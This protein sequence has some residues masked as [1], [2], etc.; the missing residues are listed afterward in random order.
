LEDLLFSK[1]AAVILLL[2]Q[3]KQAFGVGADDMDPDLFTGH[4]HHC[5][6]GEG[7]RRVGNGGDK[8]ICG[9]EGHGCGYL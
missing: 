4:L 5:F 8:L 9:F 1:T 3:L 6:I 7:F 2:G